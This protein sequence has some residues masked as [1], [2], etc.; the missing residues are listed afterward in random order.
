MDVTARGEGAVY[1]QTGAD[2]AGAIVVVARFAL[3][4]AVADA[5]KALVTAGNTA[6]M[7]RTVAVRREALVTTALEAHKNADAAVRCLTCAGSSA[8]RCRAE[9]TVP[10]AGRAARI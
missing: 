1:R 3:A 4:G 6:V 10:S 9:I 7:D 5:A 8:R 2:R